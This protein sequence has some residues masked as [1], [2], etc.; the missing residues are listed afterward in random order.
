MV[1]GT[2]A[3]IMGFRR[4]ARKGRDRVPPGVSGYE[5]RVCEW[6]FSVCC[7]GIWEDLMLGVRLA[8]D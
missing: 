2:V 5:E 4:N 8:L 6:Y 3:I 1:S 7:D